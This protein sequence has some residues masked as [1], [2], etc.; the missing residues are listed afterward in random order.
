MRERGGR[1]ARR[2]QQAWSLTCAMGGSQEPRGPTGAPPQEPST[3]LSPAV[4]PRGSWGDP[5]RL[6]PPSSA[7]EQDVLGLG[8]QWLGNAHGARWTA[9]KAPVTSARG[10]WAP[11]ST[12]PGAGVGSPAQDEGEELE[13]RQFWPGL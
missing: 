6:T 13:G 8:G 7:L 4:G 9:A 2:W 10:T 3:V 11:V 5:Y 12:A 1:P